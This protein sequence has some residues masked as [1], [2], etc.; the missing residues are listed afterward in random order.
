[1]CVRPSSYQILWRHKHDATR[2]MLARV[3][4]SFVKGDGT[5]MA[6]VDALIPTV[7]P[8]LTS[9]MVS[10]KS[11]IPDRSFDCRTYLTMARWLN[12]V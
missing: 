12:R 1:M 3:C 8:R 2:N 4:L 6:C 5:T 9:T 10:G 7:V 11:L